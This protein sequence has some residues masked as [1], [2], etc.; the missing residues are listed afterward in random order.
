VGHSA[1]G[2][3]FL[4]LLVE[5]MANKISET[6]N[7]SINMGDDDD[8]VITP[9]WELSDIVIRGNCSVSKFLVLNS[10]FLVL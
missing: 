3:F 1:A 2:Y 9:D 4:D 5:R 10:K 7:L 8:L 6:I